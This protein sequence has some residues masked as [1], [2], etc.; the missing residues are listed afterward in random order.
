MLRF[1]RAKIY[2][3]WLYVIILKTRLN[4]LY[5]HCAPH[6]LNCMLLCFFFSLKAFETLV[7]EIIK[8]RHLTGANVET[9]HQVHT[10]PQYQHLH[11]DLACTCTGRWTILRLNCF[12]F[13]AYYNS[14]YNSNDIHYCYE[15]HKHHEH[16][17]KKTL[18][19]YSCNDVQ[20][21]DITPI[22]HHTKHWWQNT[23]WFQCHYCEL[24]LWN[25]LEPLYLEVAP[26]N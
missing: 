10:I 20:K 17:R 23:A 25:L 24:G 26:I 8:D 4:I 16:C 7:Q 6:V 14:K 19:Y 2:F 5:M 18:F 1:F 11:K 21:I 9:T 22:Q 3:V 15:C 12:R 13:K